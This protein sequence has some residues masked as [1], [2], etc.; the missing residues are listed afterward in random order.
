MFYLA[1]LHLSYVYKKLRK[2]IEG[3]FESPLVSFNAL[4]FVLLSTVWHSTL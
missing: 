4:S 3:I 1:V 2:G